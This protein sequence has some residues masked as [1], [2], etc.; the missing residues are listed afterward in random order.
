MKQTFRKS[1]CVFMSILLLS[2]SLATP[3]SVSAAADFAYPDGVNAEKAEQ[4]VD[5]TDTLL[6][7]AVLTASGKSLSQTFSAML[8]KGDLLSTLL[9]GIYSAMSSAEMS[10]MLSML[11]VDTTPANL[12][13]VLYAYPEISNALSSAS[14][15]DSVDLSNANWNT[16]NKNDFATAFGVMLSPLH[17]LLQFLL[18]EGSISV[19]GNIIKVKGGNGYE[20]AVIPLFEAFGCTQYPDYSTYKSQ[21]DANPSATGANLLLPLL[22][23]V[24]KVLDS[25]LSQLC[26]ILPNLAYFILNDGVENTINTLLKP[27]TELAEKIEKIPLLNSALASGNIDSLRTDFAG[28]LV[29]DLNT[30]L[31]DSDAGITLPA[32]D[33]ELLACC[34]TVTDNGVTANVGKTFIVVFRWLWEALQSNSNGIADMLKNSMPAQETTESLLDFDIASVLNEFLQDDADTVLKALVF[35]LNPDL[36]PSDL[37]WV[38]GPQNTTA[39]AFTQDMP[40]ENYAEMIDGFDKLLGALIAESMGAQTLDNAV[41]STLYTNDNVTVLLKTIYTALSNEEIAGLVS[42]FGI[43]T[44]VPAVLR[45]LTEEKYKETVSFLKRYTN[46]DELPSD[47]LSWGFEDGDREGFTAACAAVLRPFKDLFACLLAGENFVLLDSITICGGNGYNSAVIPLFEALGID[48]SFYV[49]HNEY[50]AG[51]DTDA[52]L[53]NILSPLFMQVEKICAAPV[54]YMTQQLPTISYFISDGGL[55]KMLY[56]LAIPILTFVE[57]SGLSVDL[58]SIV[59]QIAQFDLTFGPEQV[60][61]LLAQLTKGE[62]GQSMALPEL[63]AL[64]KLASLGTLQEKDSKRTF[65]GKTTTYKYVEAD[66]ESVLA[67]IVDF[68]VSLMQM[69]ENSGMM[70]GSFAG[71][72]DDAAN[73]FASYTDSFAADM[74]GM[75][76]DEMVKW[77]Y[78]MLVFETED[79]Q[80]DA[81]ANAEV[82]HIIYE[83]ADDASN[84][85]AGIVFV[86]FAIGIG[87][88][89][90][91][92]LH[93]KK[94]RTPK[95]KQ[96]E[97]EE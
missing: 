66:E 10:E 64:T 53:T 25:P 21:S 60:N 88:I 34:G 26:N 40:R 79:A 67:Y 13:A 18:C 52:L 4:I 39:Y 96:T 85:G 30:M 68:M 86:I 5:K 78:D 33:W 55:Q 74:E 29:P 72:A 87:V 27:V 89:V 93:K 20:T 81:M 63:P 36:K 84:A 17:A 47:G 65:E 9:V 37:Y 23:Y 61:E 24:E 57:G 51:V 56:A 50:K 35:M 44:S 11:S 58:M 41:Q 2:V 45:F 69:P 82:P 42:V 14:S 49:S 92:F 77:F 16:A 90:I 3:Y 54:A 83:S 73:P 38:F 48:E 32:I 97:T 6:K 7:K 15:W 19:V 8:Y 62:N 70:M 31:S 22:N 91:L 43:N 75:S 95:T 76:H 28:N 1:V 94:K 71:S 80:E 59:E 46:W 12:S